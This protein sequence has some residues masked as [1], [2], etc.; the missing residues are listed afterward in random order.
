VRERA[1]PERPPVDLFHAMRSVPAMA[2][3]Q[4]RADSE[5]SRSRVGQRVDAVATDSVGFLSEVKRQL[6]AVGAVGALGRGVGHQTF[7]SA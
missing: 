2:S 6:V 4:D 5:A 1:V 3:A 7:S